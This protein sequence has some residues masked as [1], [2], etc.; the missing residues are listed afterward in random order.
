MAFAGFTKQLAQQALLSATKDPPPAPAP[1][2]NPGAAMLSQIAAMQRPLK[3]EEEL[4]VTWGS[5]GEKI[6]VAEIFLPS[7]QVA[8]LSGTDANRGFTR[9]VAAVASLQLVCR[10]MKVPAGAKPLR[11]GLFTPKAKDSSG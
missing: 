4:V 11:V 2:E 8:I 9:V 3:E 1:A 6:R 10:V 5:G 7:P